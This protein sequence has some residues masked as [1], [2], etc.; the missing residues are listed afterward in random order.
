MVKFALIV[1]AIASALLA[2]LTTPVLLIVT[3]IALFGTSFASIR[4]RAYTRR[5]ARAIRLYITLAIASTA[6]IVYALW[7]DSKLAIVS[8]HFALIFAFLA[9]QKGNAVERKQLT[10]SLFI[11]AV[12][13]AV[14]ALV[15]SRVSGHLMPVTSSMTVT[16]FVLAFCST[17]TAERLIRNARKSFK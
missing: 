14:V 10:E 1:A 3:A 4:P 12:L 13:M 2:Y 11:T 9:V 6:H 16:L 15:A 5:H 7:H 17:D 8:L